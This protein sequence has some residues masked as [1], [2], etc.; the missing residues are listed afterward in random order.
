MAKQCCAAAGPGRWLCVL[1]LGM[2]AACQYNAL[3]GSIDSELGLDFTSL[4]LRKQ[5]H[6]LLIEYLRESKQGTEKV[7]KVVIETNHLDLPASGTFDLSED[8]F[9]DHVEL[10]RSTFSG[11]TYPDIDRGTIHFEPI[12]FK[13]GG[14]AHGSFE[15]FFV[16]T[17]RLQG[18]FD[19][20]IK[21][22]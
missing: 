4:Q 21:E 9:L 22:I 20:T 10:Q 11:D 18:W 16:N 5:D 13:H 7:C 17:R 6:F 19:G 3:E 2:L 8:L 12:E 14:T 15:I 1:A